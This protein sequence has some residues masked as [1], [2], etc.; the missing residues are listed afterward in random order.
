MLID[1]QYLNPH[2]YSPNEVFSQNWVFEGLVSYGADGAIL[3]ALATSWAFADNADG[4]VNLTFQLRQGV[5]FHDGQTWNAAACKINFDNVFARP[6][7]STYHSWCAGPLGPLLRRAHA[8]QLPCAGHTGHARS[9][10]P[11]ATLPHRQPNPVRRYDLPSRAL[12]WSVAGEY[13][14]VL[15][16]SGP[17]YPALNELAIIRP[18]RFLSPAAFFTGPFENS[19]PANRGN[20]TA[21]NTFV[22][23]RGIKAPYGTG[24]WVFESKVT[25]TRTIGPAA[26]SITPLQP[27]EL[28]S[29]VSFTA[30][31]RYWG[32]MPAVQRVITPANLDSAAVRAALV[33]GSIDIAYGAALSP[34]DFVALQS[35]GGGLRALTSDPL[36]TRVLL[37]NTARGATA[38]LAVRQAVNAVLDRSGLSRAVSSLEQPANR[39][40]SPDTPYANV[41]IGPLPTFSVDTANSL[42]ANDGW[43]YATASDAVRSKAGAPLLL[44]G[45]YTATDPT[46][47]AMASV[48]VSQLAAA[49]IALNM[50][51]LS[52]SAFQAAGFAG[53][54]DVILTETLGDPYDPQSFVAAWRTPR[55]YEFPAQQGLTGSGPSGMSKAALDSD[56]TAVLSTLDD[57]ARTA[58]WKRILT[59][60]NT[61]ALFAPLTYMATRAVVQPRV[62]GFVFGPQ[63][64]DVPLAGVSV[65][66]LASGGS[67][68]GLS[69]GAIAGIVV[70][71]VAFLALL[72]GALV[73]RARLKLAA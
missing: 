66:P 46:H 2:A 6:L 1:V 44:Q 25:N 9:R 58:T 51:G 24:P 32:G 48:L 20:V 50:T 40:F 56:I 73:F 54:F 7:A 41:D 55:S 67:G 62:A 19:C 43:S 34:A 17:Y 61:E 69:A 5:A 8:T 45:V 49:G 52:K 30:N 27:G 29:S 60:V 38:S 70:G 42:L 63:Q 26:V 71:G 11:F 22:L 64:F 37:L 57:A 31:A 65:G 13:T 53:A 59:V 23:C 18:L 68:G 10:R 14:F 12:S 28:V 21:A 33:A 35:S 39:L 72:G 4:T 47:A 3:P 15:Q 36:Q 16:L